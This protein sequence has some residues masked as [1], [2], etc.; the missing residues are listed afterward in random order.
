M[1]KLFLVVLILLSCLALFAETT[2]VVETSRGE[3]KVII[4]DGYT[5]KDVL[6][7][8]AQKYYE[9]NYSFD[10]LT[11][12]ANKL[13]KDTEEY[14]EENKKLR[15][16]YDTLIANYSTVVTKLENL[17]KTTFLKGLAGAGIKYVDKAFLA[18]I[19][20]GAELFER[21]SIITSI[22]VLNSALTV[23]FNFM[24]SF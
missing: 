13:A 2:Y 15:E 20:L 7:I 24:V 18:E 19:H 14:I 12:K 9:L 16:N 4:P 5:E 21:L 1:K 11:E 10:D 8:I 6:L 22:G 17:S 3:Q 23:G